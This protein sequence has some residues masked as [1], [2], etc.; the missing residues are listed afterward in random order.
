[1]LQAANSDLAQNEAMSS[2]G[3]LLPDDVSRVTDPIGKWEWDR[4]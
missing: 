2:L 1:M 4:P 3:W